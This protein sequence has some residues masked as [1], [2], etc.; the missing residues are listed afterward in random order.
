MSDPRNSGDSSGDIN[1]VISRPDAPIRLFAVPPQTAPSLA[2][3]R[4]LL[5][6]RR[7][8]PMFRQAEAAVIAS[9]ADMT[10]RQAELRRKLELQRGLGTGGRATR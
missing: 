10:G 5:A 7:L 1:L 4:K 6:L 9:R 3:D 8:N 2:E